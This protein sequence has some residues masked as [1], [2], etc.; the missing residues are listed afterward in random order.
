MIT[1]EERSVTY[2]SIL[3][4][5]RYGNLILSIYVHLSW[6]R[7]QI[8]T[9][10]HK[11][12]IK[13]KKKEEKAWT[14]WRGRDHWLVPFLYPNLVE[15][16]QSKVSWESEDDGSAQKPLANSLLLDELLGA[17]GYDES[18]DVADDQ[19]AR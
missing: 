7:M 16:A 12:T 17:G 6:L 10:S 19:P 5:P 8:E 3:L 11:I 2:N 14:N 1:T 18:F 9:K 4:R 15:G 13:E